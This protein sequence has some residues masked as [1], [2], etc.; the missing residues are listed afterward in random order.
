M[1]RREFITLLGGATAA[2]PLAARAQRPA[3][4]VVAL[5]NGAA[6]AGYE[7]MVAAFHQGLEK[8]GY[9][10]GRNVTVEYHWAAGQ[11]DRLPAMATDLARR[12]VAV[13]VTNSP[14]VLPA[15]AATTTI[16]IVFTTAG[17]PVKLGFVGSLGRPGGNVTGVTQLNVEVAPLRLQLM[18][19]L[20]PKASSMG[21]LINPGNPYAEIQSQEMQAAARKLG[22]QVHDLRAGTVGGI[23][24]AFATLMQ[25]RA[26]AFVVS[27]DGFFIARTK[28][29]ATL[30][31]RYAVP[32][33]FQYREFVA[34][35]GLMSY[36]G[37]ITD[38]YHQA[39]V[40]VGRILKGERPADLPVMQSTKVELLINLKTAQTL[41]LSFPLTLLGRADE[42]IE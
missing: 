39:G 19:E 36:S 37:S 20:L 31:L 15:K 32:T 1:R 23:D 12:Q 27:S 14:G 3:M 17:D 30:A 13:I 34:A 42:V 26:E 29:L 18:H 41:G 6:P 11:Y 21:V 40:Y 35:G 38:S 24:D 8:A 4:P 7:A 2:W 22:L 25:L 10:D 16:P 33:I 28:Q 9:V 5:L